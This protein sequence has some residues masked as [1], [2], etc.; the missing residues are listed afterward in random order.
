MFKNREQLEYFHSRILIIQQ[1]ISL[2]GET[3]SNARPLSQFMKAFSKI[4]KIKAFIAPKMIYLITLL[5]NNR[6]STVYKR[7]NI[8][9]IYRYLE[10]IGDPTPLTTSDQLSHH[11]GPTSSIKNNTASLQPVIADILM[12]QKSIY[13]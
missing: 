3:V 10:M 9:V 13:E 7:V 11:L 2:S 6:K 8:H 5:D 1:E 4:D 12:R